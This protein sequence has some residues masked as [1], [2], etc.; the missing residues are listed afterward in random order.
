MPQLNQRQNISSKIKHAQNIRW[1]A[2]NTGILHWFDNLSYIKDWHGKFLISYY[3]G[4]IRLRK[5]IPA[6]Y[7]KSPEAIKR[8]TSFELPFKK[9]AV[10]ELDNSDSERYKHLLLIY[11]NEDKET[12]LPLSRQYDVLLDMEC[13]NRLDDPVKVKE[14]LHLSGPTVYLLS[15]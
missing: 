4:L 6:L 12:V 3:K 5:S 8:I 1:C 7:D 9:T 11:S 15:Y 14:G 10:I 13:S 2:R